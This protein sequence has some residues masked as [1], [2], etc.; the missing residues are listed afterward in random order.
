MPLQENWEKDSGDDLPACNPNVDCGIHQAVP[1]ASSLQFI[2]GTKMATSVNHVA[3]SPIQIL[4]GM[5][6]NIPA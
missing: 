1:S 4:R 2:D 5:T 6:L 3:G